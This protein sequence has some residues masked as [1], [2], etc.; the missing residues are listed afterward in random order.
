MQIRK[1][2]IPAKVAFHCPWCA[3]VFRSDETDYIPIKIRA[4]EVDLLSTC[5]ICGAI[6]GT[7]VKRIKKKENI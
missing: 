5:P 7:T 4:L 6:C 1:D 2:E 3:Q